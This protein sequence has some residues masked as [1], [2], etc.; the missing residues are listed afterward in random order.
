MLSLKVEQGGKLPY[1]PSFGWVGRTSIGDGLYKSNARIEHTVPTYDPYQNYDVD[2]EPRNEF[3]S[4]YD[5]GSFQDQFGFD[6]DRSGDEITDGFGTDDLFFNAE[7]KKHQ[8]NQR[9]LDDILD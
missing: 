6:F 2:I 4:D 8:P 9:I 7:T 5:A 3:A 1:E